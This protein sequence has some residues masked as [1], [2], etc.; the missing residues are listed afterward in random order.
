MA[1]RPGGVRPRAT[2][3]ARLVRLY[4]G[5]VAFGFSLAL[6]VRARLGLDPW[7]VLHQGVA[8]HL[9]VQLGWVVMAVSGLVLL[10]WIPLR[11]RPGIGTISNA[12]LVGLSTNLGL[13]TL[14]TPHG[15]AARIALLG[16][17]LVLNAGASGLY[18]SARLGPGPRD[19]LMT[20][21]AARGHSIRAV[22]TLIEVSV[23]ALGFVL[24]GSVGVGT[25]VWAPCIGPLVHQA[26]ARLVPKAR[27]QA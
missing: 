9:H 11:Q 2:W 3:T 19:G 15:L 20:G 14:A 6:L 18:L 1:R 12:V 4:A 10:C 26:M 25:L 21:L 17:A 22:R 16:A 13:D 24:G 23:L 7:D 5:L 27:A 8:R